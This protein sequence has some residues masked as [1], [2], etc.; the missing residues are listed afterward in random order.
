MLFFVFNIILV[1]QLSR[2]SVWCYERSGL[3]KSNQWITIYTKSISHAPLRTKVVALQSK[4]LKNN[5]LSKKIYMDLCAHHCFPSALEPFLVILSLLSKSPPEFTFLRPTSFQLI[6]FSRSPSWFFKGLP[7]ADS[8]R[9]YL[10]S[11]AWL[12]AWV[13]LLL[14]PG[15]LTQHLCSSSYQLTFLGSSGTR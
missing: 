14:A 10:S 4:Q 9:I 11:T 12:R 8:P 5:A 2:S 13:L 7:Y 6:S 3:I 1:S 15:H